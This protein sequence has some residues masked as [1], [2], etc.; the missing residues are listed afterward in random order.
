MKKAELEKQRQREE[1]RKEKQLKKLREKESTELNSKIRAEEK[2][3][4]LAQRKLEGIRLLEALFDRIKTKEQK[5]ML[6]VK[7]EK[8]EKDKK[9]TLALKK[10]HDNFDLRDKLMDKYKNSSEK[11]YKKMQDRLQ[12]AKDG[13]LI[14]NYLGTS[15]GGTSGHKRITKSSRSPSINSISSNDSILS[16]TDEKKKSKKKKKA[17]SSSD[18][19]ASSSN[20]SSSSSSDGEDEEKK[21]P[22][23]QQNNNLVPGMGAPPFPGMYN[24]ET[25]EWMGMGIPFPYSFFPPHAAMSGMRPPFFPNPMGGYRGYNPRG[26]PRGRYMRIRGANRGQYNNYRG[27]GKN[28]Y[29]N[30]DQYYK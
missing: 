9:S 13:N 16:D 23:L 6:V 1:K 17:S 4:L 29:S 20:S 24:P 14:K 10:S 12:K 3:L 2:K 30:D 28:I 5:E 7:T 18:A 8:E 19:D 25:G 21:K 26:G 15:S 11:E 27:R 22:H